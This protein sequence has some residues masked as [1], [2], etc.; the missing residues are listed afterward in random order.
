MDR[1]TE[2]GLSDDERR[3]VLE[4]GRGRPLAVPRTTLAGLVENAARDRP[5]AIAVTQG[6]SRLTYRDLD[7]AAARL[8]GRLRAAGARPGVAVGIALPRTPSMVVALL[9]ALKSGA[10]YLPLDPTLPPGRL[11]L[12]MDDA[13]PV[14]CVVDGTTRRLLPDGPWRLVDVDADDGDR[15]EFEDGP[16]PEDLA[17]VIFTS[18]STGRPKGICVEHRSAVD[19]V[20]GSA[21]AYRAGPDDRMLSYA[22]IG[23]DISVAEIFTALAVGAELVIADDED[24]LSPDRVQAL[25]ARERV[26]IAEVPPALLGLL[27]PTTLPD[28]RLMIVGG[29]APAARQVARW[30]AAGH[31]VINAYG[32]TE[33]TVTATLME[34][35]AEPRATVPIGRPMANHWVYVL[36]SQGRLVPPGVP[37]ELW[38]GGPGVARGYLGQ[39]GLTADRFVPDPLAADRPGLRMYRSGDRVSWNDDGTLEFL[40]RVDG[41]LNVRGF[42]IE[43]GEVEAR[44]RAHPS[45]R[46]AGV[47]TWDT[48]GDTRLVG[49]VV[50]D[51]E[52]PTGPELGAWCA[53]VLPAAFIPS[54]FVVLDTLPL[55]PNGKLDRAALPPPAA[56]SA[57][58]STGD[59]APRTD[60]ESRLLAIWRELL[61]TARIGVHDDLFDNGGDSLLAMRLM[62]R[63]RRAFDVELSPRTLYTARTIAALAAE[64]SHATATAAPQPAAQPTPE[65]TSESTVRPAAG[66]AGT[67]R[68]TPGRA[69]GPPPLS[70]AQQQLWFVDRLTPGQAAYNVPVGLRLRGPIDV[71]VLREAFADVVARHEALRCSVSVVDDRPVSVIA[72]P[73]AVRLPT[74]DL[75][76]LP[77]PAR[78]AALAEL[79]RTD[80]TT[81]FALDTAPLWRARL[82]R[83]E[84]DEWA[85]VFVAHHMIVDGWSLSLLLDELGRYYATRRTGA[86]SPAGLPLGY[87]DYAAWQHQQLQGAYLEQ[88][89]TFWRTALAGAPPALDLPADRP[90]PEVQTHHPER[91]QVVLTGDRAGR[92]RDLATR[93]RVTPFVAL[94]SLFQVLLARLGG[95]D[96]VVVACPVAGRPEPELESLI[97]LFVNTVPIRGDL[98]GDPT[99]AQLLER[100]AAATLDAFENA[101]VP[102]SL[103]V[104]AVRPPRDLSRPPIAQVGFN[105]LNYPP[106]RLALPGV[107]STPIPIEPPGSL[108]D[109]TLYVHEEGSDLR[110][111]VVYN[112]DLFDRA[113]IAAL[114]DQYVHLIEQADGPARV[115][116]LSL[117]PPGMR[118]VLPDPT[119]PL[120]AQTGPTV[121]E[122]FRSHARRTPDHP[123]V[124]GADGK[125]SYAELDA[126]SDAVAAYLADAGVP[127]GALVA[128]PAVRAVN[129]AVALLG[130]FKAGAVAC[131]LDP[132]HPAPRLAKMLAAVAPSAWLAVDDAP[133][134]A[135]LTAQLRH[136]DLVC[137]ATVPSI[138]RQPPGRPEP[139]PGVLSRASGVPGQPPATRAAA[140]GGGPDD[141]AYV[142]FT[143]GT[144]GTPNA[145][146]AAHRPL[147]HFTDWYTEQFRLGPGDRFAVTSG[148]AHDPVFRDLVVPLCV[149]ATACV[150]DPE[151]HRGPDRLLSWLRDQRVTVLH[152]TPQ[153]A[154]LLTEAADASGSPG[155]LPDLRLVATGGDTLPAADATALAALAPRAEIVAFYGATETP[156]AMAWQRVGDD[157]ARPRVPLGRGIPDVQLLVLAGHGGLAG[158]GELGEIIVRTPHL[159]LG[160]LGDD[161]LTAA[162]FTAPPGTVAG[163]RRYRTGDLGRYLPD[164]RVEF[165]GRRDGQVK[166]RGHRVELAEVTA[167]LERHRQVRQALVVAADDPGGDRRLVAYVVPEAGARLNLEDLNR[168]LKAALP[169][170]AN[171]SAIVPIGRIPLGPTGKVDL[172]ALPKPRERG[173]AGTTFRPPRSGAEQAVAQAWRDVLGIAT[174]GLDD[175]FFDL[176]GSSMHLVKVQRR[177]TAALRTSLPVVDLFR[178]PTVRTLAA[179]LSAD[180]AT[181]TPDTGGGPRRD[182]VAARVARR[183]DLRRASRTRRPTKPSNSSRGDTA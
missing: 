127:A 158:V 154:R 144:T 84:D 155:T 174:V 181:R 162:R 13:A 136:G 148:V 24:R 103:I 109:L 121:I 32:P 135:A 163:D 111:E 161:T 18:G 1:R 164:G 37:G 29:E 102:F 104:E 123:A 168:H 5:Q 46:A 48:D 150:P 42:R 105:L 175:N 176:G 183:T 62:V 7:V 2:G 78:E 107:T 106:E 96:D 153:L 146:V 125:L 129:L 17:Y 151:T 167:V 118:E 166:I 94:L 44:L 113:R 119:A 93:H 43:P 25:L 132:T 85:F 36:D 40:G 31:R 77:G 99:V 6:P 41:Q 49:Y 66:V 95:V 55:D 3:L 91:V 60:V 116:S 30:V 159:A 21:D 141:P 114:L 124:E 65:P 12:M 130:V 10:H 27:D 117:A 110:F 75:R 122:R 38:I 180:Q 28:L 115:A 8:A 51:G 160:Y 35:T 170:Y 61:P 15:V 137:R 83:I 23:F 92:V 9:A 133:L 64:I 165:A 76:D 139:S 89:L 58:V 20:V 70:Y 45:V 86:P 59:G 100:T 88:R 120:S 126:A 140:A 145:V 74:D 97:G 143:S 157:P 11:R 33:T 178:Y 80:A 98:S 14:A 149:G 142:L 4:W 81:P 16:T 19:L 82:V 138:L 101:D 128:V 171:P 169:G 112:R 172:A 87:G 72:A 147:A 67:A 90:R 47:R 52:P 34:C 63:V 53:Q 56:D 26:T 39:P 57:E 50:P 182:S 54:A 73:A 71:T 173:V 179:H 131:L 68:V 69:G 156:Q 79:I 177:L 22:S 152:V 108:L 134:P